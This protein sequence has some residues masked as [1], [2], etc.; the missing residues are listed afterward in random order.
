M[1]HALKTGLWLFLAFLFPSI[2]SALGDDDNYTMGGFSSQWTPQE[3]TYSANYADIRDYADRP[4]EQTLKGLSIEWQEPKLDPLGNICTIRGQVKMADKGQKRT[5]PINWFQAVTVYLGLTPN[6]KPDWS[7]GMNQTDTFSNTTVTSPTGRFAAR[8]DMRDSKHDRDQAQSFQFGAALAKH[9]VHNKT[10]QKVVWNSRTPAIPS[11]VQMLSIPAAP[12]LSRELQLINR[13]SR[14]PFVKWPL[15][16][17]AVYGDVPFM[18]GHRINMCGVPEQPWS[19]ID[20]ARLHGVIRDDPLLPT[21]NP[22]AAAEAILK[23]RRFTALDKYP[24]D[25]ATQALRSQALAMVR[26][27][28]QPV[29]ERRTIDDEQWRSRLKAAAG[30][31]IRWDAVRQQFVRGKKK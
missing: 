22:L 28:V 25:E 29:D 6:A 24:R 2:V 10:A 8:F 14:W 26:G 4:D 18:V 3:W 11:S 21:V 9:I 19:H 15:N 13:A 1:S 17:V 31:Q 27:L 12:A 20:W 16:P 7:K 30:A 5:K 23:S